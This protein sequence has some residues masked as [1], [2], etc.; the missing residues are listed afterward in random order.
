MVRIL[1]EVIGLDDER[2]F[3]RLKIAEAVNED[4]V[5]GIFI[6]ID[7]FIRPGLIGGGVG[8]VGGYGDGI[9][10]GA[11]RNLPRTVRRDRG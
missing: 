6:L 4:P 10:D 5:S 11:P 8:R 2:Y 9:H 7:C 3:I 1:A